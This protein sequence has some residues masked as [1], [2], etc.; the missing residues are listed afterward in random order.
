[1]LWHYITECEDDEKIVVGHEV[2]QYKPHE[3]TKNVHNFENVSFG[4]ETHLVEENLDEKV[5]TM[6]NVADKEDEEYGVV[7]CITKAKYYQ[8]DDEQLTRGLG[9]VSY[10]EDENKNDQKKNVIVVD[11][12]EESNKELKIVLSLYQKLRRLIMMQKLRIT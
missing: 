9:V 2:E 3:D 12:V 4:G 11:V 1:M 7:L 10:G 8:E 5:A 6:K